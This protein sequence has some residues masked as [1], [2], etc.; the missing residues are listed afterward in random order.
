MGVCEPGMDIYLFSFRGE[1][2][3]FEGLRK[4]KLQID[5][6]WDLPFVLRSR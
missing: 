4:Q 1:L 3:K 5:A 2:T 6:M